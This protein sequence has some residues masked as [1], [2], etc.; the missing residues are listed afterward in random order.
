MEA[1]E[2]LLSTPLSPAGIQMIPDDRWLSAM[3]KCVFQAGFNW[4]L[5]EDKWGRFEEV[6]AGFDIARWSMMSD[7]DIDTL[8]TTTG[9]VANGQKIKSI[10]G[11]AQFLTT[12]ARDHGSVGNYFA[13][14]TGETYWQ[15]LRAL[16]KDGSRVGGRTGQIFLRRMGVDTLI[17][18]TDVIKALD[19]EGVIGKI[20]SSG[21][22]FTTVQTA[23]DAWRHESGRPLTQ[24]SQILA[25]SV[26]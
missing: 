10:G 4:Q 12:I 6:F 13:G 21:K 8:L 2:R 24:I 5:I 7:D 9:I 26:E 15:N 3:T 22:D 16:H 14:W 25:F 20:P 11:N 19:R 17:F 18:S 23:I 1:L